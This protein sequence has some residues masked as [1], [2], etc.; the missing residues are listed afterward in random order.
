MI[1][2]FFLCCLFMSGVETY[3]IKLTLTTHDVLHHTNK[4]E[5]IKIQYCLIT[6]QQ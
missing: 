5:T 1:F 2:V 3:N 4:K 6:N